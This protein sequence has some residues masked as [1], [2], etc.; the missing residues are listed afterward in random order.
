MAKLRHIRKVG[1]S[2]QTTRRYAREG[3]GKATETRSGKEHEQLKGC[4]IQ[5]LG[6]KLEIVGLLRWEGSH[7]RIQ[8]IDGGSIVKPNKQRKKK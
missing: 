2:H 3:Y 5:C 8:T 6:G 4:C 7:W 1:A